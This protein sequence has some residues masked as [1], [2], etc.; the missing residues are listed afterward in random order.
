VDSLQFNFDLAFDDEGRGFISA[1]VGFENRIFLLDNDPETPNDPVVVEIPGYSGPVAFHDGRLYYCTAI[2]EPGKNRIVYFTSSQL[3]EGIGEG[4]QIDFQR[5]LDE[6]QVVSDGIN[7]YF[8]LMFA[9]DQLLG[10]GGTGIDRILADGS[11]QPLATIFVESGGFASATFLAFRPGGKEFGSGV[12]PEG[13]SLYTII[14]DY[15]TFNDIVEVRPLLFFRRGYIDG[16]PGLNL[17]DVLGLI[18]YLFL[19]EAAFDP[20]AAGDVND[21]DVLDI[22]DPIYLLNYLYLGGPQPPE[23]FQE[24]GPD[25]T[26]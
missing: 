2:L 23:P 8:N 11:I 4:R 21:D 12:G 14:S 5:A 22:T 10:T 3:E 19:G 25:P 16:E 6:G 20:L 7:N 17:T 9:G 24:E 15:T 18:G 1:T 26:P 13:G